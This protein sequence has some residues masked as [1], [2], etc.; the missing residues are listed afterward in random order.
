[1][2]LEARMV[3]VRTLILPEPSG[4][5]ERI[6]PTHGPQPAGRTLGSLQILAAPCEEEKLLR[7]ARMF[8]HATEW[9]TWWP[10]LES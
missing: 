8:E 4:A 6:L 2:D 5:C 7:I 1:M 9:H 3:S 10:K